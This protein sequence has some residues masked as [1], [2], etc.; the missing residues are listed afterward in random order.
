[1]KVPSISLP[2]TVPFQTS[3]PYLALLVSASKLIASPELLA[4]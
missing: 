4:L 3:L 1:M 2:R